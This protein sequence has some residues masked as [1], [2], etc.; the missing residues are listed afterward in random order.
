M[1][2]IGT[3]FCEEANNW[4]VASPSRTKSHPEV[5]DECCYSSWTFKIAYDKYFLFILLLVLTTLSRKRGTNPRLHPQNR[6]RYRHRR[7]QCRGSKQAAR[8][9]NW[10]ALSGLFENMSDMSWA[11]ITTSQYTRYCVT[12]NSTLLSCLFFFYFFTLNIFLFFYFVGYL[13]Q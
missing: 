10:G 6:F 5:W 12:D 1:A 8:P 2:A 11:R 4:P 9:A 3:C 7:V 13:Y